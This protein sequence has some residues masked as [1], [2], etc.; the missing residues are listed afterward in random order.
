MPP[1]PQTL[2][3]NPQSPA[4]AFIT[5]ASSGIGAAFAHHLAARGY[6]LILVA[7]RETPLS[8]LAADLM[9]RHSIQATILPADLTRP[10]DV[11]HVAQHIA[12]CPT[13]SILIN[14]AGFATTAPFAALPLTRHLAMLQ[15]H[16]T[17]SLA[18]THAALPG[19]LARQR[20]TIITVSSI[21]AFIPSPGNVTYS[22]TKA[23]LNTFTQ[24]LAAELAGTG[25]QVQALCPGYTATAFHDTPDF[26]AF[27]RYT[28]AP[29]RLWMS[30]DAVVQASLNA[31]QRGQRI[32]IPGWHNRLLL[33][34][35]RY[36]WLAALPW[37]II[38]RL[39]RL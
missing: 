4:T 1:N 8:A 22:A 33:V 25:I 13:L 6:H 14:N 37:R 3:P 7:R 38:Q 26:A 17:T 35:L 29:R 9:Q 20:G 39:A 11:E 34:A 5:G 27:D 18:L 2:T 19:M 10:P 23:F 36:P 28:A 24:A 32:V 15:L 31:L 12:A 30:P 21:A 16:I